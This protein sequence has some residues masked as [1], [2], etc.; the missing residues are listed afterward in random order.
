MIE[1]L[2][3][4]VP[5]TQKE[6]D[7]HYYYCFGD[8]QIEIEQTGS[9]IVYIV[10][11]EQVNNYLHKKYGQ[12]TPKHKGDLRLRHLSIFDGPWVNKFGYPHVNR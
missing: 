10:K 7:R 12:D 1:T 2:K 6:I 3:R 8:G 5:T 11:G 9:V 4:L